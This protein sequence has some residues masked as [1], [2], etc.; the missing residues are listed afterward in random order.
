VPAMD[1]E[2]ASAASVRRGPGPKLAGVD[3]QPKCLT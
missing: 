2:A 1:G 3:K